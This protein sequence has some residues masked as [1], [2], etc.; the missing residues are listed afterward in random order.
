LRKCKF[1]ADYVDPKSEAEEKDWESA[2]QSKTLV[3]Y[4]F[5]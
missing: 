3:E 4:L 1:A 5:Q 2:R